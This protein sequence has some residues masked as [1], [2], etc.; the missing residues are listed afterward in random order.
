MHDFPQDPNKV[1]REISLSDL[2]IFIFEFK[3]L[4]LSITLVLATGGFI[5]GKYDRSYVGNTAVYLNNEVSPQLTDQTIS[6]SSY[7]RFIRSFLND[8]FVDKYL[9]RK[10]PT[11]LISLKNFDPVYDAN[12]N[13]SKINITVKSKDGQSAWDAAQILG[14]YMIDGLSY[15]SYSNLV[16]SRKTEL[17]MVERIAQKELLIA[18]KKLEK[19]Q[20]RDAQLKYILGSSQVQ[21][22][23]SIVWGGDPAYLPIVNQRLGLQIL[24]YE[25]TQQIDDLTLE[26]KQLVLRQ[27]FYS[28]IQLKLKTIS[29]GAFLRNLGNVLKAVV[30]E[31]FKNRDSKEG[32]VIEVFEDVNNENSDVLAYL[33]DNFWKE[34]FPVITQSKLRPILLGLA[35]MVFGFVLS[36]FVAYAVRWRKQKLV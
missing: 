3:W 30:D 24:K 2:L 26:Q 11:D 28:R 22:P 33:N 12:S 31:T 34:N 36:L 18:R 19:Y 35:G 4:I 7:K 23:A 29:S 25:V 10:L 14:D 9:Q 5:L 15:L 16:V 13:L 32:W 17:L 8:A 6:S 20:Q 21:K 1:E 27:E